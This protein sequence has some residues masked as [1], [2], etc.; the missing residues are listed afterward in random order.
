MLQSE[1]LAI[2]KKLEDK[3]T[4]NENLKIK[5]QARNARLTAAS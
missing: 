1:L 2:N 5:I 3:E 4:T